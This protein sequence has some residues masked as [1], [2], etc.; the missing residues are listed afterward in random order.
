MILTLY[1]LTYHITAE[2]IK[3]GFRKYM[4]LICINFTVDVLSKYF[5]LFEP[6]LL[7]TLL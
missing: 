1:L 2:A 4:H 7:I 5:R 6:V 3:N